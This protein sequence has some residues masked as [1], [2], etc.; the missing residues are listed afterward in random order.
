MRDHGRLH[1]APTIADVAHA[2]G[3][4]RATA[5]R[6]LGHYGNVREK[7][8][9]FVVDAARRLAY[10][11]NQLAKSMATG[12]SRMIGVVIEAIENP[13]SAQAVGVI[14]DIAGKHGYV[15][16]LATTDGDI[17]LERDA[18]R[19][20]LAKQVDGLI[21]APTSNIT[22][23]HLM[24]ASERGCPVVLLDRRVPAL[25]A[26][27]FAVD[28]FCASYDAVNSLIGRGHRNVAFVSKAPIHG[29][30]SSVTERVDGYRAALRDAD[31]KI[32][33]DLIL[34]G[35]WDT[36]NL[37]KQVRALCV[38]PTRPTAFLATD[39]SVAL[40]LLGVLRKMDLVIPG[41]VSFVCFDDA[42]WTAAI[43]PPLTVI[44]QPISDLAA[45]AIERLIIRLEGRA[46]G[47][48]VETLLPATL[49]HRASVSD[50][51]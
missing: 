24:G 42:D 39:S 10:R 37:A 14:A 38:S 32:S 27:T 33:L 9:N 31:I 13:F 8:R 19:D 6:V 49:I 43:T 15:V 16:I 34:L 18:V 35:G 40:V 2:A 44:S 28:N 45:A 5:A 36:Q 25:R 11:P 47:P 48:G 7:T 1:D 50:A 29:E 12:R 21:I 26:D 20:L 41:D 4:S 3:V 51:S 17:E 23:E 46:S 22:V 30:L